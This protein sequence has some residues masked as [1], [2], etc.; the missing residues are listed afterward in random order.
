VISSASSSAAKAGLKGDGLGTAL[1]YTISSINKLPPEEKRQIYSRLIPREILE[2]FQIK[3][4]WLQDGNNR[5]LIL[6]AAPGNASVELQLRHEPDFPDPVLYGHLVDT[7]TGKIHILL[8]IVNDPT[9]PRF[10]VDKMPDGTSTRFGTMSRN[11]DAELAAMQFGLAPGQVRK[12]FRLLG[13]A[14]KTFESFVE[15]LG[16]DLYYAE[17]LYYHN[18]VL[19]ERYGFAYQQGRRFMERIQ[20][21]MAEEGDLIAQLNNSTPFR[22]PEAADSIRLRSWAIHD[23]LLGEPFTNVTMYKRVGIDAGVNTCGEC[24]W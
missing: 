23:N 17:P 6:K 19:F 1:A 4:A 5:L 8:Y 16:H 11:L 10:D 21:G 14:I 13:S 3:P 12:G 15:S 24:N 20:R 2:R 22:K 18:A 7:L 9:S